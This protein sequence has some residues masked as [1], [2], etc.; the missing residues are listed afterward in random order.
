MC[1][2]SVDLLYFYCSSLFINIVVWRFSFK[3]H[4]KF[5]ILLQSRNI[6]YQYFTICNKFSHI[7][8]L[9]VSKK[10]FHNNTK[11]T[12]FN[13]LR[14]WHGGH[15]PTIVCNVVINPSLARPFTPLHKGRGKPRKRRGGGASVGGA[16]VT[17][18]GTTLVLRRPCPV[19]I[20]FKRL[21]SYLSSNV[22]LRPITRKQDAR[23]EITLWYRGYPR[24]TYHSWR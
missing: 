1:N 14:T 16:S 24:S 23:E 6:A 19:I 4:A 3:I 12:Y 10:L 9:F 21:L 22:C 8:L 15:R 7:S 5:S 17:K 11:R 2:N 18:K 20:I 13:C